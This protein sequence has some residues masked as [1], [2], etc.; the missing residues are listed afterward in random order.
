MAA[1]PCFASLA[2][3]RA[4]VAAD[5]AVCRGALEAGLHVPTEKP[6]TETLAEAV[7]LVELARARGRVLAV[8]QNYRYYPAA[9]R[10]AELVAHRTLGA[11]LAV[12]IDFRRDAVAE[13]HRYLDIPDPLLAD[14]VI[15][16]LDLMRLVLGREPV[17]VIARRWN[18]AGS[19]FRHDAS[20]ALI[21][22]LE[23][24]VVVSWR[25]T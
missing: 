18:P 6:F 11:P 9:R 22:V 25:G 5:A 19:P 2:E 14:M 21:V 8:S 13:G 15:H 16:H 4:A 10:A 3:A 12:A 20:G 23:G 7:A 24:E 1:A 17:E